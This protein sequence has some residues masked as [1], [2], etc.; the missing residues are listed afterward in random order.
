MSWRTRYWPADPAFYT[1]EQKRVLS[2]LPDWVPMHFE[3]RECPGVVNVCLVLEHRRSADR[4][5]VFRSGRMVASVPA[6]V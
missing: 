1:K 3:M 2:A 4:A 6:A 5:R